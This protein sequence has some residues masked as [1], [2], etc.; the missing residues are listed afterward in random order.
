MTRTISI[1][2]FIVMALFALQSN[3]SLAAQDTTK[4]VDPVQTLIPAGEIHNGGFGALVVKVGAMDGE[5]AVLFG[6]RGGWVINRT[7]V[8]GGGGYGYTDMMHHNQS[9]PADTGISFGYGGLELES[10]IASPSTA[11]AVLCLSP[12]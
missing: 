9:S 12:L 5:T 3:A 11:R 1:L 2:T 10:L 4:P 7:F 8:I 6:G